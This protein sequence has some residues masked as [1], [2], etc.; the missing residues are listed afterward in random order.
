MKS[1][2][3]MEFREPENVQKKTQLFIGIGIRI[4]P[5]IKFDGITLI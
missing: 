4:I 2:W 3:K 1:C 5:L